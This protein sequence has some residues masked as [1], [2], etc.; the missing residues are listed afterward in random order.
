MA[1]V[2]KAAEFIRYTEQVY[3]ERT[4]SEAKEFYAVH[5]QVGATLKTITS[6]HK[7]FDKAVKT[8]HNK[9]VL[10]VTSVSLAKQEEYKRK[11]AAVRSAISHD[12]ESFVDTYSPSLALLTSLLESGDKHR[13]EHALFFHALRGHI[14]SLEK[15]QAKFSEEACENQKPIPTF[16]FYPA[17]WTLADATS[18]MMAR[19]QERPRL[20]RSCYYTLPIHNLARAPHASLRWFYLQDEEDLLALRASMLMDPQYTPVKGNLTPFRLYGKRPHPVKIIIYGWPK[21][22]ILDEEVTTIIH[23]LHL[24]ISDNLVPLSKGKIP[25]MDG[26]LDYL[27]C[28]TWALLTKRSGHIDG[29]PFCFRM[30]VGE[31]DGASPLHA[32]FSISHVGRK[33]LTPRDIPFNLEKNILAECGIQCIVNT[34]KLDNNWLQA[35]C[36]TGRFDISEQHASH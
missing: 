12:Y 19:Q 15:V 27:D 26:R 5:E 25:F 28:F 33:T 14:T 34:Q 1:D 20:P 11:A 29:I 2:L 17:N 31:D 10:K 24:P 16:S 9:L 18:M 21:H 3:V 7:D 13:L 36:H 4:R 8:M 32:W 6:C 23:Q 35:A 30:G 22:G